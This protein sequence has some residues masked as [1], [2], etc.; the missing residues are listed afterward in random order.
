MSEI[1]EL[2]TRRRQLKRKISGKLDLLIGHIRQSPAMK[3]P[4]MT[5]KVS[6]KTVT[7]SIRKHLLEKAKKMTGN[8]V[9]VRDNPENRTEKTP[10][11]ICC[12][13]VPPAVPRKPRKYP[14]FPKNVT[15]LFL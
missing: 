11:W 2:K 9:R 15:M 13:S 14:E 3:R 10:V 1:E 12:S 4:S 7:R 5:M 8:H 6:G